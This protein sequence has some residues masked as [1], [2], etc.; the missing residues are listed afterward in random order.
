MKRYYIHKLGY[1]SCKLRFVY[2][3]RYGMKRQ[4]TRRSIQ[5]YYLNSKRYCLT[6]CKN[7]NKINKVLSDNLRIKTSLQ[8]QKASSVMNKWYY[9]AI[10]SLVYNVSTLLCIMQ[11][12]IIKQ[13]QPF[14]FERVSIV[15]KNKYGI[16]WTRRTR[17][18]SLC[19]RRINNL[20]FKLGNLAL[21]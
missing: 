6:K 9:D 8:N 7:K 3:Q 17:E 4:C 20:K 18:K 19:F 21:Q 15:N 5:Y 14:V 13:M 2:G 16:F 12:I 1:N 11:V 10:S